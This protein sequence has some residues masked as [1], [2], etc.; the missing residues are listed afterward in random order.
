LKR[1]RDGG[2]KRRGITLGRTN[3]KDEKGR[4]EGSKGRKVI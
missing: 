4:R 3:E 2:K 1:K